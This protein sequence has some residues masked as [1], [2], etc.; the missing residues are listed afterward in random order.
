MVEELGKIEKPAAE[1]YRSGK[2]IFFVPLV[3]SSQELPA[4]YIEKCGRYW[5]QVDA[6]ISNLEAGIGPARHIFHELVADSGDA[7]L[8]TLEQLKI[9]SYQLI[10]G[11][12]QKGAILET[13][14]DKDVLTELTDWSRCLSLGL[15]NQKVF[16]T[17][18]ASYTEANKK[19]YEAISKKI[20]DSLKDNE[21]CIVIL[22]ENHRVQFTPDA[23]V[24]YIAP[25]ILD[26]IKRWIRDY[27]EKC[28]SAQ[29]TEQQPAE[30][31]Q[32]MDTE[33]PP[34]TT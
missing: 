29:Q 15:Q 25:P 11:R 6:Q 23:R 5:E 30:E 22:G 26:E 13:T 21:A 20:S 9:N 4:D 7:G 31:P 14:E 19:R 18:Y 8:K 10:S 16:S 33:E 1:D 3:F 17:I 34:K 28:Q 27:E 24:F 2:K 32:A 12:M